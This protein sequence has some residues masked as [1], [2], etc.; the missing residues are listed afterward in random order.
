MPPSATSALNPRS[1]TGTST[2]SDAKLS[3]AFHSIVTFLIAFLCAAL[4][5]SGFFGPLDLFFLPFFAPSIRPEK[6]LRKG[7]L[8]KVDKS[9]LSLDHPVRN[10]EIGAKC[11]ND[12]KGGCEKG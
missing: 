5:F 4:S 8:M 10:V 3:C 11:E 12:E 7:E 2:A 6:K 1:E 9:Q